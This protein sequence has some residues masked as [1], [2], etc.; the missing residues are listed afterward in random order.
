MP[1]IQNEQSQ[2][3]AI[4]TKL[5]KEDDTDQTRNNCSTFRTKTQQENKII[6]QNQHNRNR[7]M[8]TFSRS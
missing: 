4:T 1:N 8:N 3:I 7:Y 5:T 6:E 2:V